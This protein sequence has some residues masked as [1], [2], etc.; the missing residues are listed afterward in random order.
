MSAAGCGKSR[1]FLGFFPA[2]A[3]TRPRRWAFA[4][5]WPIPEGRLPL[6]FAP[7]RPADTMSDQLTSLYRI[8]S[9]NLALR[10]AFIR[11][12]PADVRVLARLVAWARRTAPRL[13]REFYDVQFGFEQT[14][15]FFEAHARRRGIALEVLRANLERAQAGYFLAIFEEAASG[16]E[17]GSAYFERR[18]QV[19]KTHNV[20]NLPLKWF[21]GSYTLYFDLA[22]KFLARSYPFRPWMRARAERA[23]V[24]VMNYDSQAVCDA[25][26]YDYLQSIGLDLSRVDV[27]DA[28][29]DLSEHYADLKSL[30]REALG[31]SV[32]TSRDVA[33]SSSELASAA[34][35][36][37][38]ANQEQ[39]AAIEQTSATLSDLT[40][41]V[42]DNSAK[43]RRARDLTTGGDDSAGE[44]LVSV[45]NG[46]SERSKRIANIISL[47]DD[48]AF[49]TNLLALNAAV[50]AARAGE[51]GRGFAVVAEEVRSLALRSAQSARE[52]K[53]LIEDAVGRVERG[54]SFVAHV[55]QLV[56]EVS[57]A[58]TAQ[59]RSI[60][61]VGAAIA[62]MDK[63]TQ[64]SASQAEQLSATAVVLSQSAAQ[65]QGA[66]ESF[67]FSDEPAAATRSAMRPASSPGARTRSAPA[68]LSV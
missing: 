15:A 44:C 35:S 8:Q 54:V 21:L 55:A 43:A 32:R 36:L 24:V 19:G 5:G 53:S 13:A 66:L 28:R 47:M 4:P 40:R 42:G 3:R 16:G 57:D 20:I 48:I 11:L 29:H 49:Q 67:E 39:A 17:F 25:F 14:R 68:L 1:T 37:S 34:D 58:S 18:L 38:H 23:L 10:R 61:E 63:T 26:F 59:A 60:A 52:I 33:G 65:L 56:R 64:A 9:T 31:S 46:V 22:R 6:R 62:Q 2:V 45:M 7:H 51:Q 41:T 50:E 12:G 27:A 30:V